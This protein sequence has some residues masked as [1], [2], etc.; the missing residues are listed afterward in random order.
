[1][2]ELNGEDAKDFK[3]AQGEDKGEDAKDSKETKKNND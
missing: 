3:R 1:L 2:E